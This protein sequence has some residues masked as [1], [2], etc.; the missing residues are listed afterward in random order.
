MDE[1]LDQGS[2]VG[3]EIE[4]LSD[5][6]GEGVDELR[7]L[8][9]TG[10]D[11]EEDDEFLG[12]DNSDKMDE[13]AKIVREMCEKLKRLQNG[14]E[15]PFGSVGERFGGLTDIQMNL[16]TQFTISEIRPIKTALGYTSSNTFSPILSFPSLDHCMS[17]YF[18]DFYR[19]HCATLMSRTPEETSDNKNPNSGDRTENFSGFNSSGFRW[20]AAEISNDSILNQLFTPTKTTQMDDMLE[21]DWDDS[22]LMIDEPGS[23]V[24]QVISDVIPQYRIDHPELR[25]D[26]IMETIEEEYLEDEMTQSPSA[27]LKFLKQNYQITDILSVSDIDDLPSSYTIEGEMLLKKRIIKT[28]SDTGETVMKESEHLMVETPVHRPLTR[29]RGVVTEHEYVMSTPIEWKRKK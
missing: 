3:R 18:P 19:A 14:V 21:L 24:S 9:E 10:D 13:R 16:N 8:S 2:I 15:S 25:M 22:S 1:I 5:D 6:E 28:T 26:N 11:D 20:D 4:R 29:S 17:V 7:S 27:L 12:F 23:S